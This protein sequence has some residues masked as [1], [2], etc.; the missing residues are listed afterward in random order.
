MT[1]L[2]TDYLVVGSGAVGIAY[3]PAENATDHTLYYGP[4]SAVSTYGYSG[5]VAGLGTS[6]T[7]SATL[8][9]GSHFFMVVGQV[10]GAEGCYGSSSSCDERPASP[11]A[12]NPQSANRYCSACP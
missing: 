8:P 5:S 4:L 9:A 7:G 6:G 1:N 3:M 2:E 12:V 11:G 10:H